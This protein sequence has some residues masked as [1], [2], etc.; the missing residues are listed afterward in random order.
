MATYIGYSTIDQLSSSRVL[1]DKALAIRDLKNHFYTRRGERVMNPEFGSIIWEML[2]EPLD[3]Y[4]E[5]VVR[6]DV[7]R[8]INSDPRWKLLGTRLQKPNEHSIS[9]QAQV[10]YVDTGTAEELYLNFVG[11]IE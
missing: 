10:E 11:E 1:T 3:S 6:D 7:E 5:G 8:I 9:V 4:T 2:F